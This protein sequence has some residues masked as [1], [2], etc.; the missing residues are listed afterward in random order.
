MGVARQLLLASA[1]LARIRIGI[2]RAAAV[3]T[4]RTIAATAGSVETNCAT[5]AIGGS[6]RALETVCIIGN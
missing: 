3:S 6:A 5:G 1:G 2:L 4:W